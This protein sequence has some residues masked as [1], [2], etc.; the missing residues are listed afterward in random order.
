M[1]LGGVFKATGNASPVKVPAKGRWMAGDIAR[2]A[3]RW[4][5]PFAFNLHVP[6]DMSM[7]CST[8]CG[9]RRATWA[10]RVNSRPC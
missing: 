9:W 4:G 8:G 3:R 1:L 2:W 10:T 7:P 6:I 5:V